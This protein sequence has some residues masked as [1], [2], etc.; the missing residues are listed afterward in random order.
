MEQEDD[1]DDFGKHRYDA[2]RLARIGHAKKDSEDIERQEWNDGHLDGLLDDGT[3]LREALLQRWRVGVSYAD[4]YHE[5]AYQRSHHVEYGGYLQLEEG[6]Q[7]VGLL[8][9]HRDIGIDQLRENH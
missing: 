8:D 1:T 6:L 5:G 9:R 4:A 3:E 2:V 7:R